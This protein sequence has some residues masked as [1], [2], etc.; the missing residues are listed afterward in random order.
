MDVDELIYQVDK[1]DLRIVNEMTL[2][3]DVTITTEGGREVAVTI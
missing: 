2:N 1:L 3:I